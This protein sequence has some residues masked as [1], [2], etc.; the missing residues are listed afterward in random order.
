MITEGVCGGKL[1]CF[2]VGDRCYKTFAGNDYAYVD[3]QKVYFGLNRLNVTVTTMNH[4]LTRTGKKR[5]EFVD[6][7][8]KYYSMDR[9]DVACDLGRRKKMLETYEVFEE[10]LK[11][12]LFNGLFA[13][14]DNILRNILVD[15]HDRLYAI[16]END[17]F[18]KRKKIFNAKEPIK[19][20]PFFNRNVLDKILNAFD[21]ER[22]KPILLKNLIEW[23]LDKHVEALARRIDDYRDICAS[24]FT[25]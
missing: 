9:I 20:S 12:R 23:N 22:L 2:Y 19:R 8:Q 6:G 14:S 21:L 5:Y 17:V 10:M 18:G 1:P 7:R 16:D 11:I 4:R 25:R 24:E 15:V 3:A 13:T